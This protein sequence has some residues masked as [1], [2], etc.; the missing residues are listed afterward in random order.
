[1]RV[2]AEQ[3]VDRNP[4]PS[5]ELAH[6]LLALYTAFSCFERPLPPTLVP[7][8]YSVVLPAQQ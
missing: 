2:K 8:P 6:F 5:K 4:S 1:M 7:Y 3:E